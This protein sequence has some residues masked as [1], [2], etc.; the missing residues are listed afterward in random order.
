MLNGFYKA[1]SPFW[2]INTYDDSNLVFNLYCANSEGI[3]RV[4]MVTTNGTYSTVRPVINVKKNSLNGLSNEK[5]EFKSYKAGDIII[6]KNTVFYVAEDSNEQT[7]YLYLLRAF[8]L[9]YKQIREYSGIDYNS[10]YGEVPYYIN[11]GCT[12]DSEVT[13]NNLYNNSIVKVIVDNYVANELDAN[14]LK[15]VDGY[16]AKL[17]SIDELLVNYN[18]EPYNKDTYS[19]GYQI[20][21]N[22]PKFLLINGEDLY[23][24][25]MD[26]LTDDSSTIG[27]ISSKYIEDSKVYLKSL[28][29]PTIYLKK[30]VLDDDEIYSCNGGY[31]S[32]K[33]MIY[34]DYY[35]GDE[36]WYNNQKYYVIENSVGDQQYVTLMKDELLTDSE[37]NEYISQLEAFYKNAL[38]L[39]YFHENSVCNYYTDSSLCD[40]D[41]DYHHSFIKRIVDRW[42]SDNFDDDELVEVD[43]YRSRLLYSSESANFEFNLHRS[44]VYYYIMENQRRGFNVIGSATN[45]LT[46]DKSTVRPI[47]Y[48][49]KSYLGSR[50]QYSAGEKVT[51]KGQDYYVLDNSD[52]NIEYVALFKEKPLTQYEIN[53]IDD[54][55]Y[56]KIPY[57]LNEACYNDSTFN[58]CY[59]NSYS[60]NTDCH[61]NY[62]TS[63]I[64][65]IVDNWA[66][67]N[68]N[69]T[70]L[71]SVDGYKARLIT[72]YEL[73][74]YLGYDPKRL[75]TDLS[76]HLKVAENVPNWVYDKGSYWTM[77]GYQD[78]ENLVY[79]IEKNGN[80]YLTNE[81]YGQ[82][83]IRPVININ[84]CALEDG[85]VEKNNI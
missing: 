42:T 49:K 52:E 15:T 20:T 48:L 77:S 50:V 33:E 16:K 57:Y 44:E 3:N 28:I 17:L 35:I 79:Y 55:I 69:E 30:E 43:G 12:K 60:Y 41:Y 25:L 31:T 84:K 78:Y 32:D 27:V 53:L 85:C 72:I 1:D 71:V 64:K 58:N 74:H 83:G 2:V 59:S 63:Y 73:F 70:D 62:K 4:R 47:I 11:G 46:Y 22:T 65:E 51:Y 45:N 29:R 10:L 23:Y 61:S 21:T 81:L 6:Y 26:N 8:P 54:D 82:R 40:Y 75:I 39:T 37:I 5:E 66:N 76:T 18:F 38:G 9:S 14:D 67:D 56:K 80:V 34:K 13:C 7:D 24:W 68:F 19:I 36:I